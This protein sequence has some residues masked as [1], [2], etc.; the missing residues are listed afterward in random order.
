[1]K[2]GFDAVAAMPSPRCRRRDAV[3]AM[4]MFD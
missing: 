2:L 4:P 1:V 3:A